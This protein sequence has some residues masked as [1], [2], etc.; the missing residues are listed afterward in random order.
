MLTIVAKVN[1]YL[2]NGNLVGVF[3]VASDLTDAA[4]KK[5]ELDAYIASQ[6]AGTSK[7]SDGGPLFWGDP[8][9]APGTELTKTT[10]G[11]VANVPLSEDIVI[12]ANKLKTFSKLGG[13]AERKDDLLMALLTQ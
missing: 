7:A 4:K 11:Y 8:D 3:T 1:Q 12:I 2:K 13:R 5:A 10:R 6:P 9:I